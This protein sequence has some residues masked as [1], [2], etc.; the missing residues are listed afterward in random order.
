[1]NRKHQ[2]LL[3]IDGI[4]NLVIGVILLWFPAGMDQ[5]L[6]LPPT[7]AIFYPVILG[8]VISGIGIALIVE[9][10][11]TPGSVRGLGLGGAIAINL[12]GGGALLLFLVSGSLSI[13]LRGAVLL[14]LL[15]VVVLVIGVAEM[16]IT[17]RSVDR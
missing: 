11:G 6:G 8:A 16:A 1:M 3:A 14:W 10:V 15:A 9:W 2:W 17:F 4:V 7:E 13:P 5:M 12:C